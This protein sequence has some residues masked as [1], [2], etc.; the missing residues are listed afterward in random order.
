VLHSDLWSPV[1]PS[2]FRVRVV[3]VRA[4]KSA[5]FVRKF[6]VFVLC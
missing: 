2:T 6:A 5:S 1:V 4:N 3:D